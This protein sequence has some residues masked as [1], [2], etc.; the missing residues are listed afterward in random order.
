MIGIDWGTTSARAYR[1]GA[2]IMERREAGRGILRIEPGGF[3]AA[4]GELVGDWIAAGERRVLLAGMVGSRQGW[5]EAPYLPCPAGLDGLAQALLPI[6]FAGAE[7]LLVP[8]LSAVDADGVP[9]VMRGEEVQVLGSAPGPDALLCLPGTHAKWVRLTG[10]QVERFTTAMTGEVFAAMRGHTILG[11]MMTGEAAPGAAFAAGV[12]RAG[13]T[14]GLLHHLFGVRTL[15]L[16]GRLPET[17]AASYL[18]G[19]LIGHE[20]VASLPAGSSVQLVG[21]GP[22]MALYAAAIGQLGGE[23]VLGDADAAARGLAMIGE[24]AAWTS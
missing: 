16:M 7:V 20:I 19:L 24:R 1:L 21:T 10:G 17:D 2:G 8:G 22:L 13:K 12:A 9:E 6:P 23:P 4:L 14:G 5:V 15:G 11:R 3:P 18:S